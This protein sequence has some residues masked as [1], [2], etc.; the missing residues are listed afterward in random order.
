MVAL[1]STSSFLRISL[2]RTFFSLLSLFF[3]NKNGELIIVGKEFVFHK[4]VDK[5][6][7]TA[8]FTQIWQ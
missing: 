5:F 8:E 1:L 6:L 4:P 7:D 3:N 2:I